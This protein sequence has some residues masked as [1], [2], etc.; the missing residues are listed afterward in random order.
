MHVESG[1][2]NQFADNRYAL[3]RS[4]RGDSRQGEFFH[5][6]E[7][8]RR[9]PAL[10]R[11]MMRGRHLEW[12]HAGLLFADLRAKANREPFP[13]VDRCDR[14]CEVRD[15]TLS[16]VSAQF[17]KHVVRRHAHAVKRSAQTGTMAS[18]CIP[19]SRR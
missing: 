10:R 7:A 18:Q 9:A 13:C 17:F 8:L 4:V 12:R 3:P 5:A 1:F 2:N 19:F 16:V 6:L 15:L 11:S 14:E